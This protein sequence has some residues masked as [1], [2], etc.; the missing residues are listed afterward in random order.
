MMWRIQETVHY[1]GQRDSV[2]NSRNVYNVF[3]DDL[4]MAVAR[5]LKGESQ[6]SIGLPLE[7]NP[8][9]KAAHLSA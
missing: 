8:S 9:I 6:R 4:F 7:Y 3:S 1:N 5:L 2:R